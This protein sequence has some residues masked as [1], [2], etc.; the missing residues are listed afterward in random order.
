MV[1]VEKCWTSKILRAGSKRKNRKVNLKRQA[2]VGS[3]KEE[4][5]PKVE[6]LK[7]ELEP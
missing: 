5:I 3:S 1:L 2:A 6:M 4:A 7:D